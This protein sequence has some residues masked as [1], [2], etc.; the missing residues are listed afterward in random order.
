[1]Y[2]KEFT[3]KQHTPI[4]HF[5]ANDTGATLR[6]SEVK[7]KLDKF[8]YKK[9][10]EEENGNEEETFKKYGH[11]T[12]GKTKEKWG[13]ELAKFSK[14]NKS[15]K[16]KYLKN[17][18]WALDYAISFQAKDYDKIDIENKHKNSPMYFGNMGDGKDKH[19]AVSDGINGKIKSKHKGLLHKIESVLSEFFFLHNFGTRQSK[20]YGSFT[21]ESIDGEKVEFEY[22]SK[23]S[24][25]LD[26]DNWQ[27]AMAQ[28]DFFYKSLRSGINIGKA[29]SFD[30]EP[31]AQI[32]IDATELEQMDTYFYMKLNGIR[33]L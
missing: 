28:L 8:I 26:A 9:W 21:V 19:F 4:I 32:K 5:Q 1:M 7:P 16:N 14:L 15:E 30:V 6:A 22:S 23:Y 25:S 18:L 11:F 12:I 24:F 31:D 13:K 2:I 3:L 27:K 17:F 20:G 10:S 33:N 29:Q